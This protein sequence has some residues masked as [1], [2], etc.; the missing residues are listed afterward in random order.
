MWDI[1]RRIGWVSPE[2]QLHFDQSAPCFDV[3]GS[4]F[5]D[6]VGLYETLSAGQ[7][8]E[9]RDCLKQ[10]RLA[11]YA[12]TPFFALSPGLQRMVLLARAL[13]KRPALLI[14]DEPCQ[15]LD[16]EQRALLVGTVDALIRGRAVTAIFVSHH[17]DTLPRAITRILRLERGVARFSRRRRGR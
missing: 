10:F 17:R 11:E 5:F 4:G 16:P 3:V 9:V 2:L 15:G 12:D 14:L 13:V 8:R 1:K 7:R 6:T